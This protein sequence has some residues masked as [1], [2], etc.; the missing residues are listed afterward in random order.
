[1]KIVL[2]TT[3]LGDAYRLGTEHYVESLTASLRQRG[4]EVRLLVG[5]PRGHAR[6]AALGTRRDAEAGSHTFAHPTRGWMSVR[7]AAAGQARGWLLRERP[8]LVHVANPAHLGVGI[9]L[10][11]QELGVPTVVTTMDFWWTCP[12]STLLRRGRQICQGARSGAEC[13]RCILADH[14]RAA[15]R[16]LGAIP[17]VGAG[18]GWAGFAL[19][20]VMRGDGLAEPGRWVRRRA[21][22]R[23]V[24]D[25]ADQVIFPSPATRDV[26]EPLLSHDRWH[27]VPY[28]L[29]P[30]WFASPRRR[31]ALPADPGQLVLGYAGSLQPHKGPDLL[32]E[33]LQRLGWRRTRVRLAGTRDDP[34][35]AERLARMARGLNAEFTGLLDRGA[36]RAFLR[37]LDVLVVPSRWPENLPYV[38]LEGQAAGIEVVTSDVVGVAFRVPDAARRFARDCAEDLARVLSELP[39]RSPGPAPRVP[40][41]EEMVE[42][43]DA[44]YRA[45][46]SRHRVA[47]D[48]RP[49]PT[50]R[51]ASLP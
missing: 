11:C 45:A 51:S 1:M 38:L 26:L 12:R 3:Q 40:T 22:L 15:V 28:G 27:L 18:V 19:A 14:P 4:H 46:V 24:L 37:T 33:A 6:H 44:V 7:G 35:Y 2:V 30:A 48:P 21:V 13:V 10:A 42:A 25:Q 39:G 47:L 36:M 43:T 50:R 32:L 20:S 8:D 23:R 31:A 17:G 5:D 34:R 49:A 41:L 29:A 9:L 16:P